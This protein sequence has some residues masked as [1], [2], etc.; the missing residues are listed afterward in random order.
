MTP[1]KAMRISGAAVVLTGL[2]A[3]SAA[4]AA[5]GLPPIEY[6]FADGMIVRFS[7]QINMGGLNFD[8]GQQNEWYF[9][10]NDNSGTRARIQVF[11]TGEVW[12]SELN[13]EVEYQPLAS[14]E[15]SQLNDEP[16]WDIRR[17]NIRKAE[18]SFASDRYGK[19]WFGQGSMASDGTA[20]V[21]KSG[22]TVIAYSSIADTAGG[23]YF[24]F[25]DGNLSDVRIKDAFS[26]YDGLSRKFRIRYDTPTYNGFG[27][28][29]SYGTDWTS[30]DDPALYDVAATYTGDF[31]SF[32]FDA[33]ASFA[34]NDGSDANIFAASASA[35][36]KA[37]GISLTLAGGQQTDD[38]P[39]GRYGYAKLGYEHK[40]FDWGSTAFSVDYFFGEDINIENSS[41]NSVG[42]AAVQNIDASNLK[43]WLLW[44]NHDYDDDNGS[45]E[46][47]QAIFGGAL[48]KF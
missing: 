36:H 34:R 8:D 26:N 48:V 12:K 21:D 7:G 5:E 29:A 11:T 41:N 40:F 43:L 30:E 20:E 32:A 2:L 17:G 15:V 44:R 35:L 6:K 39:T 33:A 10:D 24:R 31:D 22:T 46:D 47:G 42:L 13:F 3:A 19:F 25:R 27:L 45:Y 23:Q 38:G 18:I 1:S 14:N 28:R 16:N 9:V 37:T 4:R